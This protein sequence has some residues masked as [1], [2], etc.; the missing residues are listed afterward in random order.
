M[1]LTN[2]PVKLSIQHAGTEDFLE[3]CMRS[4]LG[5]AHYLF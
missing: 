5:D 2:A 1:L 3:T 4:N